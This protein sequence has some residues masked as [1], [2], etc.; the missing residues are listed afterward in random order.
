MFMSPNRDCG[1]HNVGPDSTRKMLEGETWKGGLASYCVPPLSATAS[2]MQEAD[3]VT[4]EFSFSSEE[5]YDISV[6][7]LQV[8]ILK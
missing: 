8:C 7:F 6:S 5:Q 4:L 2:C 3:K 1:L